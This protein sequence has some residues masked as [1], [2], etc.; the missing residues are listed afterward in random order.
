MLQFHLNIARI[1]NISNIE[2]AI[3]DLVQLLINIDHRFDNY[4]QHILMNALILREKK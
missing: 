2:Y 1:Q 4:N 3:Q